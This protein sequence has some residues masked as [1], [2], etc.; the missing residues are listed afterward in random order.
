MARSGTWILLV[1]L[2][3]TPAAAQEVGSFSELSRVLE[4]GD[5]V[6]VTLDGGRELKARVVGMTPDTLSVLGRGARRDLGEADVWAVAHRQEDSNANGAWIGFG[7]GASCGMSTAVLAWE[8]APSGTGA[9]AVLSAAGGLYGA[10][11]AWI[12]YG[13]DHL[14]RR[15]EGVYRRP[16]DWRLTVAPTL[17]S[18]PPRRRGVA[19]LLKRGRGAQDAIHRLG[20]CSR[21]RAADLDRA[22]RRAGRPQSRRFGLRTGAR[23]VGHGLHLVAVFS[24]TTD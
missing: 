2:T 7:L 12:G 9:L 1:S 4:A 21:G 13:V 15:E 23:P 24:F 11:G 22:G 6:R 3:A 17:S 16:S 5:E 20:G 18:R 8:R 14:I 19:E 10:V